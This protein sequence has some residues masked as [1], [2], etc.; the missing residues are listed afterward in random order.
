MPSSKDVLDPPH[1]FKIKR[2]CAYKK[3][4]KCPNWLSALNDS[5]CYNNRC[6]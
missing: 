5:Q 4:L 2:E 6:N 3:Q 1:L